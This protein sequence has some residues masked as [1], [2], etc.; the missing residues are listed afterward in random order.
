MPCGAGYYSDESDT[1]APCPNG[2]H[3][4]NATSTLTACEPCGLGHYAGV[5]GLTACPPCPINT[6][7]GVVTEASSCDACAKVRCQRAMFMFMLT[8]TSVSHSTACRTR[9]PYSI[10]HSH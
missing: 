8:S 4:A 1:C 7:S 6:V 5:A 9:V 10:A 3:G 2:R